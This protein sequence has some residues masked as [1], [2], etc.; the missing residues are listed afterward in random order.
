MPPKRCPPGC[1]KVTSKKTRKSPKKT[2]KSP[3]KTR[4]SPKK[5]RKSPKKTRKSPKKTRKSPK[6][7]RKSHKNPWIEAVTKARKELGI[8]GF[9]PVKKGSEL[10][11]LA[12][13]YH[14]S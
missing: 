3:K 4:K 1:T 11:K 13:K 12:K 6:K 2:R 8:T 9:A 5:T 14:Q 10:Y 7:T